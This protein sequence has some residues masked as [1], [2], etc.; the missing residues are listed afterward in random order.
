[1]NKLIGIFLLG[2]FTVG[3][4]M[5]E[6]GITL[7]VERQLEYYNAHDLEGFVA[8]YHEDIEVYAYPGQLLLKGM[9]AF[10]ERYKRRFSDSPN[11]RAVIPHR[12]V[13][14]NQVVDVEHVTDTGLEKDMR[15]LIVVYTVEAG[16]ISRVE[17]ISGR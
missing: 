7:P 14:G 16:L 2:L 10:R 9:N 15:E 11:V 6:D 5:A 8:Q 3:P 4:V 17:F 1:M 13:L 12:Y